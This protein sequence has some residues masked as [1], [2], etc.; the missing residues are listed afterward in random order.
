MQ[1][2]TIRAFGGVA[3]HIGRDRFNSVWLATAAAA[4]GQQEQANEEPCD[5]HDLEYSEPI[6]VTRR[7]KPWRRVGT[8]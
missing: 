1:F 5:F 7:R 2:L 4:A 3:G 8:G 6:L